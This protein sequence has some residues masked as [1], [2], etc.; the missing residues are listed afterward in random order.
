MESRGGQLTNHE[1]CMRE[2]L[3]EARAAAVEGEVPVGAVVVR[4]G[5]IIARAHNLME[6][7][8]DATAHA[9]VLAVRSASEFLGSWKLDESSL[10]V[11]LEPC[12]M[13]VGALV[14]SRVKRV[15][16]GAF[17]PRQGACGSIFDISAHPGLSHAIEVFSGVCA[18]ECAQVL[19]D[20]FKSV[21][22]REG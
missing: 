11:T 7:R 8:H 9:E 6:Q 21:R 13:C 14:L 20:F 22:C 4:D 16:F 18:E 12:P 17:D 3:S 15:V 2:A 19:Q 1:Y 10:Y 5:Q